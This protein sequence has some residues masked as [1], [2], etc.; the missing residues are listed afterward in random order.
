MYKEI[1][2]KNKTLKYW[3]NNYLVQ[4]NSHS[5]NPLQTIQNRSILTFRKNTSVK[6]CRERQYYTNTISIDTVAH[7]L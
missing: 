2:I 3:P 7:R 4:L 6:P 1:R 5:A